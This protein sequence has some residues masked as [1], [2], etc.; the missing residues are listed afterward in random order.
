MLYLLLYLR[1]L[2][3]TTK[4]YSWFHLQRNIM[5]VA[6]EPKCS[7]QLQ[8]LPQ[9]VSI[10]VLSSRTAYDTG[11]VILKCLNTISYVSVV[12]VLS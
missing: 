10:P 7:V 3:P 1:L 5:N 9:F 11:T 12:I 6:K 2:F 4:E 8:F